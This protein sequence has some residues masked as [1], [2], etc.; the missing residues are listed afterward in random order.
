MRVEGAY[1]GRLDGFRFVPDAGDGAER[2]MLVAA[3]NRVLR[4]EVAARARRLA[5]GWRRGLRDRPRREVALARRVGRPDR[6]RRD[7]C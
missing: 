2:R 1:V 3:A 6:R 7:G 4:S 5:V